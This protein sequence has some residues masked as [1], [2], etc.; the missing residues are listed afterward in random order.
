MEDMSDLD[1]RSIWDEYSEDSDDNDSE[2]SDYV[3][4]V[5]ASDSDVHK[6][7]VDGD[8]DVDEVD[9]ALVDGDSDVDEA[10]VDGRFDDLGLIDYKYDTKSHPTKSNLI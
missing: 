10:L 7:L 6:A 1:R 2:D 8:S 9:E 3:D 5:S 4:S